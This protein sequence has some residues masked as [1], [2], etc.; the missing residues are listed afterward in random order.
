MVTGGTGFIGS[1][2]VRALLARADEVAVLVRPESDGRRLQ[3]VADRVVILETQSAD[4]QRTAIEFAPEVT[5][6]LAWA[7]V[8]GASRT[9]AHHLTTNISQTVG[10]IE[11]AGRAGCTSIVGLGSQAE[12]GPVAGVIDEGTPAHPDS[13]YGIGKLA[14]G[15]LVEHSAG[16]HG[17]RGVWL[18]L[19]SAYG[20]MDEPS[21][22]IPYMI[23]ELLAG[24]CPALSAG[25]QP[26]DTLYC[27]DVAEALR[28]AATSDRCRGTYVL[29]SGESP[30]VREIA[31]MAR[32]VVA[33]SLAL[34]FGASAGHPGW[35]GS[36]AKLTQDTGWSPSTPLRIGLTETVL[37]YRQHGYLS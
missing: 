32:E 12:F 24:R 27:V 13:A 23:R 20:P 15:L 26:H 17:M 36:H 30:S 22:L 5:F 16:D 7:G 28:A 8:H 9:E 19:L 31:E 21:Y 25:I 37:W 35:R 1:H 2:L 10:I 18:R 33:P 6:H 3:G 11:L 14:A 29:A 34:E 4:L